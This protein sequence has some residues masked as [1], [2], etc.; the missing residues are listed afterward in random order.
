[1]RYN[2]KPKQKRDMYYILR[3]SPKAFAIVHSNEELTIT[4]DYTRATQYATV[5]G[6]MKDASKVNQ[7]LGTHAFKVESIG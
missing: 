1:M 6:A 2:Y 7:A 4:P 5:G 3:A